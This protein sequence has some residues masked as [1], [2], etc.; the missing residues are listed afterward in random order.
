MFGWIGYFVNVFSSLR[1]YRPLEKDGALSLNSRESSSHKY[2]LC[3]VWWKLAQQFWRRRFFKISSMYFHYFCYYLP[4]EIGPFI[5]KKKNLNFLRS[6]MLCA[7]FSCMSAN[8]PIGSGEDESVRSLQRQ[9][10]QQ[11]RTM[12]KFRSEKLTWA[13]RWAKIVQT[14]SSYLR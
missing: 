3:Q 9:R 1:Y 5:W 14:M 13:H 2:A 8:C 7:K 6:R 11:R 12:D 4:L 10:R